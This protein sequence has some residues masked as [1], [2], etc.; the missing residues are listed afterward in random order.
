M[1][2]ISEAGQPRTVMLERGPD[3]LG[4]SIV[5]GHCSPHG[6]LPIYVKTV[7]EKGAAARSG[8]LSRG[9]QILAVDGTSLEGLTHQQAVAVLKRAQGTIT[10]TILS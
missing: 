6:D 5:G 9:D 3:G 1:P 2:R 8:Q 4:F 10:L 7:F